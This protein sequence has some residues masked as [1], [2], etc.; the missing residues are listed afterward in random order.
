MLFE[1][2]FP[3]KKDEYSQLI[4]FFEKSIN[5]NW[6]NV[7]VKYANGVQYRFDSCGLNLPKSDDNLLRKGPFAWAGNPCLDRSSDGFEQ[8][9]FKMFIVCFELATKVYLFNNDACECRTV[10]LDNMKTLKEKYTNIPWIID[11]FYG[12]EYYVCNNDG[13]CTGEHHGK[14]WGEM[15]YEKYGKYLNFDDVDD[16]V[17]TQ[18]KAYYKKSRN[19]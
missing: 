1:D 8:L 6:L 10:I 9:D 17:K 4:Y 19:S 12:I 13:I 7:I 11:N 14:E 18:F 3:Y 15:W 2:V 16:I 5:E